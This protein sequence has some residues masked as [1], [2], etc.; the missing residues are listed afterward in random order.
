MKQANRVRFII[1]DSPIRLHRLLQR[2]KRST[3]SGSLKY[4]KC[5]HFLW[6]L[7]QITMW[8]LKTAQLYSL[9]VLEV[10]SPKSIFR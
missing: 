3:K 6:P 9:V 5:I 4:G 7:Q 1:P 10:G 8:L 2:H